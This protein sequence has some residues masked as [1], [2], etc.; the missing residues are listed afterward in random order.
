MTDANDDI[1]TFADICNESKLVWALK[2]PDTG[3][4][5]VCDS[6]EFD[7]TDA[8]PLWSTK[9]NAE[10]FCIEEWAGFKPVSIELEE[11]ME[12]WVTDLNEDGVMVGLD[13][14]ADAEGGTEVDPIVLARAIADY[15]S[16]A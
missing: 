11:F 7:D 14:P 3:D 13:W 5:V 9:A 12:Y 1:Q 8:M 16:M 10:D 4:W 15:E 6:A 2:D